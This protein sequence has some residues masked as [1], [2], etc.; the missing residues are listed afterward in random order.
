MGTREMAAASQVEE[1]RRWNQ[2]K[3]RPGGKCLLLL[4]QG[5]VC[6]QGATGMAQKTGGA[7]SGAS[8]V[9]TAALVLLLKRSV[10]NW[11]RPGPIYFLF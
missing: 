5:W 8:E 9:E 11:F 4:L 7:L 6:S 3:R 2:R 10:N 1:R